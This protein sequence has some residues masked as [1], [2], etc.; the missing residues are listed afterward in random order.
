MNGRTDEATGTLGLGLALLVAK[1]TGSSAESPETESDLGCRLGLGLST[2]G[3]DQ[4][5]RAFSPPSL[6]K[7]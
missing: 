7:F 3:L 6:L 4:R 1:D 2:H 5:F